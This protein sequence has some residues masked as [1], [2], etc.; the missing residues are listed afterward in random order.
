MRRCHLP[1]LALALCLG[2]ALAGASVTGCKPKVT[3]RMKVAVS[4]FPIYDLV[5]RV[6]GPDA[7]VVLVLPAG[8]SEAGF[9]PSAPEAEAASGARV[10]VMVGLGLDPWMDAL[11]AAGGPKAKILRVGDRVPTLTTTGSP[12]VEG[13][14]DAAKVNPHVWLDPQRA[15]VM[16]KAIG[17]ELARADAAHAR[18]YRERSDAVSDALDALDKE[19]DAKTR[20]WQ[21][22]GIGPEPG[23]V[24]FADRYHLHALPIEAGT[25]LSGFDTLGGGPNAATYEDLLRRD[26]AELAR[27]LR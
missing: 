11:V 16:T 22:R 5:R 13:G 4:I 6:A 3:G 19:L 10:F 27:R 25:P 15:S 20:A 14:G 2:V 21:P 23:L 8:R 7:D 17:E 1:W 26:A 9:T 24:Y 18:A 12:Y